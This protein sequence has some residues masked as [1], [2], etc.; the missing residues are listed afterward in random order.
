MLLVGDIDIHSF[1]HSTRP[2]LL[3][4]SLGLGMRLS[5]SWLMFFFR[6]EFSPSLYAHLCICLIIYHL[7]QSNWANVEHW[8]ASVQYTA[9]MVFS[10]V[11]HHS[12]QV[13]WHVAEQSLSPS[14]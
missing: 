2:F 1:N 3:L 7:T 14:L 11:S 12:R 5:Q 8:G 10:E 6:T 13:A 4:L 9:S